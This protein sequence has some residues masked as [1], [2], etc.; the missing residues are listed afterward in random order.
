MNLETIVKVKVG[1]GC[2]WMERLV[3]GEIMSK[4]IITPSSFL[5]SK[6][7]VALDKASIAAGLTG[8]RLGLKGKLGSRRGDRSLK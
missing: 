2:F 6:I 1:K 7:M 5:P 8:L 3:A 4:M